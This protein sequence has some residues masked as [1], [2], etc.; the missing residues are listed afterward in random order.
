MILSKLCLVKTLVQRYFCFL[1][2]ISFIFKSKQFL[3]PSAVSISV[4]YLIV[5]LEV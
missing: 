2:L 3:L 1:V 5:K 4:I